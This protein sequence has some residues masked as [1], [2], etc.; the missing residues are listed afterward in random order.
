MFVLEEAEARSLGGKEPHAHWAEAEGP[1]LSWLTAVGP[2]W[3][4][5][6]VLGI[7]PW[8]DR[9]CFARSSVPVP[10][11]HVLLSIW[12]HSTASWTDGGHGRAALPERSAIRPGGLFPG[13]VF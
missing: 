13:G 11:V 1:G 2:V 8:P 10:E 5:V 12:A 4:P 3:G 9:I 7:C 6:G